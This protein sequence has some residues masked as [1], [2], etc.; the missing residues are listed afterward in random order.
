MSDFSFLKFKDQATEKKI[1]KFQLLI[2]RW[3]RGRYI[4]INSSCF[5]FF[6]SLTPFTCLIQPKID[7]DHPSW[8]HLQ[9]REFDPQFYS[10]KARGN[11]LSMPDHLADGRWTLGFPNARACEEAHLVILNEITKQRSAVEYMLAPL[12]QDDLE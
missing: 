2:F 10:T 7:E 1:I 11:H 8:L 6:N 12:L 4:L 3:G 5:Y 9:I